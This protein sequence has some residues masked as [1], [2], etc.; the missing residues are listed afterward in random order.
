MHEALDV[1]HLRLVEAVA[2]LGG[3]TRAAERLHLTQSALSHQLRDAE[4]RLGAPLFVR[5]KKRMVPTPAGDIVLASARR[6]LAELRRAENDVR[7]LSEGTVGRIRLCTECYTIYSWLPDVLKKFRRAFPKVEIEVDFDSTARP[8]AALIEGRIDLGLVGS[9]PGDPRLRL[10][11]LF[12][13]ELVAVM[14]KDHRLASKTYVRASDFSDETLFVYPPIKESW[15][16]QRLLAPAGVSLASVR[17]LPLTESILE[18]VR[19]GLGLA[20][21]ARWAVA[22]SLDR[23]GLVARRV[24]AAGFTRRWQAATLA[25]APPPPGLQAFIDLVAETSLPVRR[26]KSA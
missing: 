9:E 25:A 3:V 7:G 18:M 26:L 22:S 23:G 12:D 11:S 17:T 15:V 5:T 6:V 24:T 4:T 1:R 21:L 19:G 14:P 13:D 8:V 20:V 10:Q 16:V 2:D